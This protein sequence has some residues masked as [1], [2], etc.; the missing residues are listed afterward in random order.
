MEKVLD[1]TREQNYATQAMDL[2]FGDREDDYDHPVRDFIFN[3]FSWTG[4]LRRKLRP[5]CVIT[6]LDFPNMMVLAKMSRES[7]KHK[8]DNSID[9]VGYTLTQ[10]RVQKYLDYHGLDANNLM[11]ILRQVQLDIEKESKQTTI[12]LNF[13][14]T[15]PENK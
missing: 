9:T 4:Y 11:G 12:Q 8:D 10:E 7:H 14:Y 3:A 13:D 2:V 6:P 5:G 1:I 15:L